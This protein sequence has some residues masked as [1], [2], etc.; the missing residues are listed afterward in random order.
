MRKG[1]RAWFRIGRRTTICGRRMRQTHLPHVYIEWDNLDHK[2]DA[3]RRYNST[4]GEQELAGLRLEWS[5][6]QRRSETMLQRY[7]QE[8]V[9]GRCWNRGAV[10]HLQ[11]LH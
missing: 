7:L 2:K 11:H 5:Y 9:A 8:A 3:R 6:L 4:A 1:Q 10:V